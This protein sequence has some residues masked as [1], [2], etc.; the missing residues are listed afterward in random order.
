MPRKRGIKKY[1][2]K[3]FAEIS[4]VER[5]KKIQRC[6]RYRSVGDISVE[7]KVK[8]SVEKYEEIET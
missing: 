5:Y 1:R 7:V 4:G 8:P 2:Y 3:S 6:N